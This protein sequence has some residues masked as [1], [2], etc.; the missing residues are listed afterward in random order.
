MSRRKSFKWLWWV[1]G[2]IAF[3]ALWIF[4]G[5]RFTY[6]EPTSKTEPLPNDVYVKLAPDAPE[7]IL[8]GNTFPMANGIKTAE[9]Y[10]LFEFTCDAVTTICVDYH[11][12]P[13]SQI[14]EAATRL[15]PV[16][17]RSLETGTAVCVLGLCYDERGRLIGSDPRNFSE[18]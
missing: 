7:T 15:P 17:Y 13:I 1:V 8:Y 14:E 9:G 4:L 12:E 3:F 6:I 16:R 5:S 10:P 11:D 2:V 18:R